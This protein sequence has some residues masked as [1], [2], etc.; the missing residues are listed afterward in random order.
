[1]RSV[2][3]TSMLLVVAGTANSADTYKFDKVHSQILFFVSH[4]GFTNSQGEFNDYDGEIIFDADDVSNSKVDVSIKTA[5]L[6]M[7][8]AAWNKHLH[9][10]DFFDVEKYPTMDFRS[11]RVIPID[12]NTMMVNGELTILGITRPVGLHV[13]INKVG[14]HPFSKKPTAGFSAV[15]LVKRSEW[16]MKYGLPVIGDDVEIRL[17]VEGNKVP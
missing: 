13:T 11:T 6:D 14:V 17:E 7:G 10:A 16:G 15:S 3:L 4:L 8:D 2:V 1:M 5:S 12:D 9:N